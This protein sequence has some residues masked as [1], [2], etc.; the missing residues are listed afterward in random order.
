MQFRWGHFTGEA[1][2]NAVTGKRSFSMADAV[3]DVCPISSRRISRKRRASTMWKVGGRKRCKSLTEEEAHNLFAR[4]R[5]LKRLAIQGHDTDRELEFHAQEIRAE[6]FSER[7]ALPLAASARQ[8]LARFLPLPVRLFLRL[9][10]GLRALAGPAAFRWVSAIAVFAAFY[11]SQTEMMQRD[12]ALQEAS[13]LSARSGGGYAFSNRCLAIR[14]HTPAETGAGLA[15]VEERRQLARH[16]PMKATSAASASSAARPAPAP[17]RC[18]SPSATPSSCS[19]AADASH[20]IFGCLYG[21]ELYGGPNPVA[22]VPSAVSTASA[23]QKL[24]SA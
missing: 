16:P 20:R 4:W 5:A 6:R 15:L 11:L 1:D 21:V 10:L 19:T 22:I 8:G 9:F 24:F 3:F 12:M 18:T 14:R 13:Y 2:F 23:V 7:L 17:R